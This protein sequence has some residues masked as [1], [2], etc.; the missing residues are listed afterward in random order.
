MQ[1]IVRNMRYRVALM[2]ES[3]LYVWVVFFLFFTLMLRFARIIQSHKFGGYD[4]FS[5]DR[6]D[7]EEGGLSG[8]EGKTMRSRER[9]KERKNGKWHSESCQIILLIIFEE[10]RNL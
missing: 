6:F 9:E 4:V 1:S 7:T 5:F 2:K 10:V 3:S 8:P